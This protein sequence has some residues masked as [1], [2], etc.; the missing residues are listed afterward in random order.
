MSEDIILATPFDKSWKEHYVDD[1]AL[2]QFV[3]TAPLDH[4]GVFKWVRFEKC[5]DHLFYF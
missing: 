2:D 4:D 5:V 1:A 3:P